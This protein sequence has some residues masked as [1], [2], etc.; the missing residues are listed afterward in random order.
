VASSG[1][2]QGI[3]EGCVYYWIEHGRLAAEKDAGRRWS[4]PWNEQV[5]AAC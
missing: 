5:E 1:T 3:S 4:I 2:V